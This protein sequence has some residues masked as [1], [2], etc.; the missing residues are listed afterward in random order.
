MILPL[1]PI[2]VLDLT[3]SLAMIFLSGLC[4]KIA[5]EINCRDK[6]NPMSTYLLWLMTA[7]FAFSVSRSMGHIIKHILYFTDHE[8]LWK[9]LSPVSG[10]INTVT[11]IVIAAVTLFF[12]RMQQI[13]A[14]INLDKEKIEKTS[15][16]L[17]LLN[18]DT[19]AIVS[20]RT[21][22]ELALS[23]AHDIRNPVMVIGGLI[24]RMIKKLPDDAPERKNLETVLNFAVR[25]EQLVA[26]FEGLHKE[27]S[28]SF[29][30]QELNSLVDEAIDIVKPEADKEEIQIIFNRAHK[31][32]WFKGSRHLIKIAI[33]HILRNAIEACSTGNTI[34]VTN[35]LC[36]KGISVQVQDNGPG[37][38]EAVLKHVFDAFYGTKEKGT[39][40]GLSM[41]RQIIEE[42]RGTIDIKSREGKG[43]LVTIEFRTHLSTD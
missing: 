39:G 36:D 40:L 12:R 24:R 21:R 8:H 27:M 42:H 34:L 17:L 43:T 30:A 29:S 20:E 25:L 13:M 18:R 31:A 37:I 14:Q 2:T 11:F 41:V 33:V 23:V 5:R 16:E 1:Y 3:G 7:I 22:A 35:G 4:L 10:S 26:R 19:E 6:D 28:L 32:L 38:P 9:R 15:K